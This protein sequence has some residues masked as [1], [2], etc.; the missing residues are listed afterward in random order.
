MFLVVLVSLAGM[1]DI[2]QLNS[3]ARPIHYHKSSL[4]FENTVAYSLM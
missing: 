3:Y 1:V 2:R 4:V